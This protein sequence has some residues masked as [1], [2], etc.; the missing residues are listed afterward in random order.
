[1]IFYFIFIAAAALSIL[2]YS[3]VSFWRTR[4]PFVAT[5]NDLR[6]RIAAA[7]SITSESVIYDLGSGRGTFLFAA[8]SY[9][10]K[11]LVGY[12]LSPVHYWLALAIARLRHSRVKFVRRDFMQADISKATII[13]LFLVSPIV[14]KVW[15]KIKSECAPGTIV[16]TLSDTII[17]HPSYSTINLR[18]HHPR[19]GKLYLYRV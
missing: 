2:A 7:L 1:M 16:A 9:H 14:Q 8:E 17:G 13:Y 3:V 4:V 15:K 10:P 19:T 12:E 5:P 6:K 11:T 18:P